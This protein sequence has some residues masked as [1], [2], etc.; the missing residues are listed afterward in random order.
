MA[1]KTVKGSSLRGMDL[2]GLKLWD[3]DLTDANLHSADLTDADF[4]GANLCGACLRGACLVGANLSGTGLTK[5]DLRS[6]YAVFDVATKFDADPTVVVVSSTSS[7][8]SVPEEETLAFCPQ[9]GQAMPDMEVL[10]A[11]GVGEVGP[12]CL[13]A[14]RAGCARLVEIS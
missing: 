13:D 9:C 7:V 2:Y 3:A 11:S 4:T 8:S 10:R 5:E 6:Q 1:L 14:R 12:V